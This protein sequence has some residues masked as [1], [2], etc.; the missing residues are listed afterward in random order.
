ME[1][2]R[3]MKYWVGLVIMVFAI[4]APVHMA[5]A[6]TGTIRVQGTCDYDR[7]YQVLELV[8]K[9][10]KKQGQAPLEM[11]KDLLEAAMLRA[12]ECSVSFSHVRPNGK[13]C[14]SACEKMYGENIAYGYNTM[15]EADE[16]MKAWMN[17]SGHRQNI[18]GS[19]YTSIGIGCFYMGGSYYW[20]QCFGMADAD[21]LSIS[22]V[23]K[24]AYNVSLQTN[25]KVA[26]VSKVKLTSNG[27]RLL[28]KWKRAKGIK[29]YEI[30]ISSDEQFKKAF[31]TTHKVSKDAVSKKFTTLKKKNLERGKK[32]YVRIRAYTTKKYDG[33]TMTIR[34]AWTTV[35]KKL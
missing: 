11:D 20:T 21:S 32:Y 8:N 5:F 24:K 34:G 28:L 14:F 23:Q 31:T 19:G 27:K 26:K 9:E 18:L 15:S 25:T 7:A 1:K 29:G 16:V 22:G 4:L 3:K 30:Q 35:D 17:S 6:A 2:I 12:A 13:D 10:R 33:K